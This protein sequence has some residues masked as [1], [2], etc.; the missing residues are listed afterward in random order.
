MKEIIVTQ[1]DRT[2][3][4]KL[5][6]IA[7]TTSEDG[8]VLLKADSVYSIEKVPVENNTMVKTAMGDFTTPHAVKES[9]ADILEAIVDIVTY[10]PPFDPEALKQSVREGRANQIAQ[11]Q[12]LKEVYA[13]LGVFYEMRE[14]PH[15]TVFEVPKPLTQ[16]EL[17]AKAQAWYDAQIGVNSGDDDGDDD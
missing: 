9:P 5:G 11:T 2:D 3:A 4:Q 1:Q 6:F 7:L 12:A 14:M 16:D 17:D 13:E 15:P 8:L 10:E